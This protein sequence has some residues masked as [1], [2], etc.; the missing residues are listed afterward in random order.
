MF[1]CF[2]DIALGALFFYYFQRRFYL[3]GQKER[4]ELEKYQQRYEALTKKIEK[5]EAEIKEGEER[6]YDIWNIYQINKQLLE[7]LDIEKLCSLFVNNLRRL[8]YVEDVQCLDYELRDAGYIVCSF[9]RL[10]KVSY[11]HIKCRKGKE[12][13]ILHIIS[14]YQ[15]IFQRLKMYRRF[16]ELSLSDELTA[17]PNRRYFMQRFEEE[18]ARAKQFNLSLSFFMIDIDDFKL[19]NDKYGHLVGDAVLK[20]VAKALSSNLRE[21]DLLSRFGGEEFAVILPE[22]GKNHAVS[23]GER[24]R[25]KVEENVLFVYDERLRATIS[26]GVATFPQDVK[27]KELLLEL[28]DKALY[29]AKKEGKNRVAF[30]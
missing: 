10:D 20:N 22:T 17:L 16:H 30:F 28:A 26:I 2:L 11:L 4:K 23:I 5:L 27:D 9:R 29:K 13:Q 15:L 18:F 8:I 1:Y 6:V 21:I 19:F 14:Q 7:I 12:K 25:K 24:I 3:Y